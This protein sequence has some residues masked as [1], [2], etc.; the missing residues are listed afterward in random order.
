MCQFSRRRHIARVAVAARTDVRDQRLRIDTFNRIFARSIDRC[1]DNAVRVVE[2][3][4]EIL[5]KARKA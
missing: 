1:K 4:R 2:A 5:E 3:G